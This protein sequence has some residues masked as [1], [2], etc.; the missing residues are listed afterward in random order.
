[1][2][3]RPLYCS[4]RHA[5]IPTEYRKTSLLCKYTSVS[6]FWRTVLTY[7]LVSLRLIQTC[8]RMSWRFVTT[9]AFYCLT[10]RG[11]RYEYEVLDTYK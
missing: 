11:S 1:M 8:T 7:W 4:S 3:P 9:V 10:R 2:N 5:G 6:V